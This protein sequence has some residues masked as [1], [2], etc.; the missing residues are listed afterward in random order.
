MAGKNLLHSCADILNLRQIRPLDLQTKRGLDAREFHVEPVSHRHRPGV[1]QTGELELGIHFRDQ[2]FIGHT[3]SPL[4]LGLQ[5]DGGVVHIERRI[6]G[7]AVG[8][9]HGA[10]HAFHLRKGADN[11]VLLLHQQASPAEWKSPARPSACTGLIPRT[12]LA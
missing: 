10:E 4:L 3:R 5:H 1:G 8:T 6:V 11:T 9:A 12:T 7:G 2:L